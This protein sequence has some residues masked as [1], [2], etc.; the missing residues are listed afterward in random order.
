[1]AAPPE[2]AS[3]TTLSER[4]PEI[5]IL[6]DSLTAGL[7]LDSTQSFPALIQQRLDERGLRFQV[8]NAGVSGDT[9]AGG[10]RRLEWAL[11]GNPR[12]LIVALGGNDALRGLPIEDLER[13]L[14]AIIERGKREGL[15]VILAGM[16]APPNNGP[17]YTARFRRVYRDL[18]SA[19]DVVLIPFLLEGVAGEAAFNQADGIHPN[20]EGARLVADT[21]WRALE[22]VL[23]AAAGT[24]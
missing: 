5:V 14:T 18:A 17:E 20:E 10:L 8:V 4:R 24:R 2:P 3:A 22:P 16:E 23:K 15:V 11:E 13:N 21:V 19:H 1:M 9:S 6:G 12:V 7:G